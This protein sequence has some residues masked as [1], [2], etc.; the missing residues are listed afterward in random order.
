MRGNVCC[1]NHPFRRNAVGNPSRRFINGGFAV[2]WQIYSHMAGSR[3]YGGSRFGI[4][5]VLLFYPF[6]YDTI[7]FFSIALVTDI[8]VYGKYFLY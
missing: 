3:S 6:A 7:V 8:A 1:H 4:P 2:I 5:G